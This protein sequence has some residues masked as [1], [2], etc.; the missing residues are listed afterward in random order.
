MVLDQEEFKENIE[1][2]ERTILGFHQHNK[3]AHHEETAKIAI[4]VD[5]QLKDF[6]DKSRQFNNNE[7]LFKMD[8]TDYTKINTMQR[9]FQNYYNLWTYADN[10]YKNIETWM[11]CEWESLDAEEAERFV[12]DALRTLTQAIRFF[13]QREITPILKIAEKVKADIEE[14]KPKV[15]LMVAMRKKGMTERHWEQ[16]SKAVGFEVK[17]GEGFNFKAALEMDLMKAVD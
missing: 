4:S 7:S 2:L 3:L 15:P 12:D 8:I 17:P 1:N 9:E 6:V 14:F 10:W 11:N 13:S 16:I 5:D